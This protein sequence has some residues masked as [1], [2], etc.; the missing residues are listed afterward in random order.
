MTRS[1]SI[2]ADF[3]FAQDYY[4]LESAET[5]QLVT[6]RRMIWIYFWLLILEGALRKWLVPSLSAPLLVVRDPVVLMIYFQ[7]VRCK[8]FPVSGAMLAYFVLLICFILLALVQIIMGV[9]GGPLVALY[10]LRTNFL[11]LPL[12]FIL[13]QVF[14]FEDVIKLGK[15]VLLLSI[16]MA[17]LMVLQYKSPPN[18]WINAATKADAGQLTFT[19]GRIRPPGTFS[20]ITGAA[21]F[22]VLVSAFVF[23]GLGERVKVYPRWLIYGALLSLAVVQPVSGSRTLVLGCGLVFASAIAFGILN[24]G[25]ASKIV[26]AAVLLVAVVACLSMTSFF[27]EA[28]EAFM[29]RW[30]EA[31]SSSGGVEQGLI[32][33]FFSWFTEPFRMLSDAGMIGKGVGMGTNAASALLTGMLVF[34]LAESEWS[35]VVLEA[36]PLLG[37][38][39]LF[40]R[41]WLAGSIGLRA[42]RA[43]TRRQLLPWLLSSAACLSVLTEGLSQPTNLGFM[44]L[45]SGLCLASIQDPQ[46]ASPV[47]NEQHGKEDYYGSEVLS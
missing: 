35:R 27:R 15:W 13:P 20:F 3:D 45:L 4:E 6:L 2:T 30:D 46:T 43:G 31:N 19:G 17:M 22:Y 10:G 24:P 23:Y 33:R 5:Q 29:T 36:G 37:F 9:G 41:A 44:V 21:H 7:A 40:Y 11:H 8:R 16:P 38:S 12:I 28:V 47:W 14:S 32:G 1:G 42:F 39:Y 26:V 25:R 34:L 18:S